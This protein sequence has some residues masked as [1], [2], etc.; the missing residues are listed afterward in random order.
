MTPSERGASYPPAMRSI[1]W[2]SALLLLGT[3]LAA[4]SIDNATNAA[5]AAWMVMLHRSCGITILGL[6]LLR[7]VLRRCGTIP[8]LPADMPALQRRAAR[9]TAAAFYALLIAQPLL[10]LAASMLHGD[11]ILVFGGVLVPNLLSPDRPLARQVFHLHG[12]AATLLLVLIGLHVAAALFH[13]VIR[14]DE[15]LSSMLPAMRRLSVRTER[16][17][18]RAP[19]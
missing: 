19:R 17:S 11:R 1:H 12:L 13:H 14:R 10:G 18:G 6:T 7:L 8:P 2:I 5:D 3:Y 16:P 9:A 4:W 15:V